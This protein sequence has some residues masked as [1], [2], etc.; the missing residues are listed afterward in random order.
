MH[1]KGT[2]AL[3]HNNWIASDATHLCEHLLEEL[4]GLVC[5]ALQLLEGPLR[6]ALK[7]QEQVLLQRTLVLAQ[8]LLVQP[9]L[10]LGLSLAY[11]DVG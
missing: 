4:A 3:R 11:Q 1:Q 7:E 6:L 2:E 5:L 9:L 8:P 10:P